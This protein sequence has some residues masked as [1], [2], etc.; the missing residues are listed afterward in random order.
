M[1][2]ILLSIYV[3]T[4]N[5]VDKVVKQL[6]FLISEMDGIKDNVEI[7]VNNNCST[8]TTEKEVLKLIEGT[9][10]KYHRNSTNVGI[11]GNIYKAGDLVHGKYFW[12]IG[13][14]DFLYPGIV[15]RV[16]EI[17][18]TYDEV[19]YIFLNYSDIAEKDKIAYTGPEGLIE[20]GV[21][22]MTG[23]CVDQID[24]VILTAS[25]IYLKEG[26]IDSITNLPLHSKESYGCSGFSSLSSLKKG[27][28]FFESR[29]WVHN[30][31]GNRSWMDI[32]YESNRG[33]MRMFAKLKLVGYTK[34]E[35]S[36]IYQS[37]ITQAWLAGKVI[38][39]FLKTKDIKT[40]ISD[41]GFC[42]AKAPNKVLMICI[43]L[44]IGKI[45][46]IREN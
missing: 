24:V 7:V 27:K 31:A 11:V 4:Y 46:S 2:D 25:S 6:E 10:I 3:P 42:L 1:S 15:K 9:S 41:F 16:L 29:V 21:A 32:T 18:K 22:L 26:L 19:S 36:S 34:K 13:D 23:R 5:R 12:L 14:D 35:I 28:A 45:K 39:H 30:D 38:T 40:F 43:H 20:D 37:W 44:I 8:D 33:M 17:I